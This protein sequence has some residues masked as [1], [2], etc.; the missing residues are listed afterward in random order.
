M[1]ERSDANLTG[2]KCHM[3]GRLI[4]A[5]LKWYPR[6]VHATDAERNPYELL[7]H[8]SAIGWPALD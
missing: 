4:A 2:D 1:V 3:D 8:G 7:G 6:L 5:P